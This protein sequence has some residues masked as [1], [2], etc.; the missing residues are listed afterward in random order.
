MITRTVAVLFLLTGGV[1]P[2]QQ[3]PAKEDKLDLVIKGEL[4]PDDPKDRVTKQPS[5]VHTVKLHGGEA[6]VVTLDAVDKKLDPF[7][8]VEDAKGKELAQD[9]DSG[10]NLN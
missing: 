5:K 9:D 1:A 7:L 10:G 8:R 4:K 3:L 2:E 6:Y